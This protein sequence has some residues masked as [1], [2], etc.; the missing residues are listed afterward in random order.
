M[1]NFK[2]PIK[3]ALFMYSYIWDRV[4]DKEYT[5]ITAEDDFDSP[6][7]LAELFL[8]NIKKIIKRGLYKEYVSKSEEMNVIKGKIDIT[9]MISKQSHKNGKI[10]CIYDELEENNLFNQIIKYIAIRL[11]KT[12]DISIEN[13]QKLNKVI[14]YFSQ[15]DYKE[16]NKHSFKELVFNRSNYYY[17]YIIKICELI[18][19]TQMLSDKNG[20]YVFYDLF[21][22]DENMYNIF[23]L[24]VYKFY[25]YELSSSQSHIM[26]KYSVG[27]QNQLNWNASGGNISL[28]PIMKMDTTIRSQEETIVLDTKYYKDYV[29]SNYDKETLI[30]VNMYQMMAYLN[31]INVDNDLRGILLYPLPFNSTPIDETYNIKVVSQDR[32]MVDAKIQFITIDLSKDWRNIT[33]DLLNI[34]D[35]KIAKNKED[36]LFNN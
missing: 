18:F 7:I 13:K 6:N 34:V 9:T 36:E 20:K 11:Y 28:L 3:N 30:S 27:Y 8:I 23:E 5:N 15:V 2:V 10:D 21:S 17:F 29:S 25:S 33:V 32:G 26:K 35:P 16:I 31:N 12:T 14:L 22:S 4:K 1:N 19:N 24:F